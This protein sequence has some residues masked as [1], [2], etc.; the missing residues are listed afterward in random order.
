MRKYFLKIIVNYHEY[1]N[2]FVGYINVSNKGI[3]TE[4]TKYMLRNG[5]EN[6]RCFVCLCA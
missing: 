6:N 4:G 3:V 2:I 1:V 5:N